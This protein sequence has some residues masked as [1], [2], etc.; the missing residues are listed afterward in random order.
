[1]ELSHGFISV[2]DHVQEHPRVWTERLSKAKWGDR[3]PH[4]K[5]EPDGTD[6]WFVDGRKA[7][8]EWASSVDAKT[9]R[10]QV[11]KRWEDISRAS[12]EPS[13]RLKA[14]NIDKVAYSVLYP[15]LA[16]VAGELFGSLETPELEL[17]CVQ[18][19]NDWLIEEWADLSDRFVPQCIVPIYPPA[20]AATEIQRA[21]KKGHKGVIYPTI[22]MHIRNVPHINDPE[23][24]LIWATCEELGVPLCLHAGS[25][26]KV[27]LLPHLEMPPPLAAALTAVTRPVSGAFDVANL[28][29][30]R[31]LLRHPK[32]KVVFAESTIGWG[33][34]L[35]EY[36]DHQFAQDCL[37]GYELKPSEI[38]KRQCFFTSWYDRVQLPLSQIGSA[39]IMW[40]T[41]F[42]F[43]NSTWPHSA[44]YIARCFEGVSEHD[45]SQILWDNAA[46]LYGIQPAEFG[47]R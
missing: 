4:I 8:F 27:Q 45:Q 20:A 24:D 41:N 46:R 31:I 43:P 38:F 17:A 22:P 37:D 36:A 16:G 3:I 14:M 6:C 34:F 28:L 10:T 11:P 13:E 40:A 42:P 9:D 29:F 19:Y 23:Y 44:E 32:L 21:V 26:A 39:N 33:V 47:A 2:D 35:L 7:P 1:M 12:W 18:A 30:S 15:T 5:S 25:S